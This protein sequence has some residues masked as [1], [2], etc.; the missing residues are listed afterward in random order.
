MTFV[1]LNFK[2]VRSLD[3]R[4]DCRFKVNFTNTSY[5]NAFKNNCVWNQCLTKYFL[6][7]TIMIL[8]SQS[9]LKTLETSFLMI[10]IEACLWTNSNTNVFRKSTSIN[11]AGRIFA[12]EN[13]NTQIE[14]LFLWRRGTYSVNIWSYFHLVGQEWPIPE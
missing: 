13:Q 11:Q 4:N 3:K 2:I 7:V 9:Q 14:E 5:K 8:S 12:E 1:L 6:P 10:H